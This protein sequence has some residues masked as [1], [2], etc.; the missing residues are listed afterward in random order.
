[1]NQNSLLIKEDKLSIGK[2]RI[3]LSEKK[4]DYGDLI[5]PDYLTKKF[6][7]IKNAESYSISDIIDSPNKLG[8]PKTQ[9]ASVYP[10]SNLQIALKF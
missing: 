3:L 8:F 7:I 10:N 4:T 1:M 5:L 2:E 9:S 6:P